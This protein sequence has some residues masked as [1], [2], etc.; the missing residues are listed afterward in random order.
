MNKTGNF[1][2]GILVGA[3]AGSA[4]SLLLAPSEGSNVRDKLSYQISRLKDKILSLV[5]KREDLV[6]EAKSQGE[7]NV[8]KTQLEA[9][10]LQDDIDRIQKRIKK[11][12]VI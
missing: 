2:A 8:S 7:A 11:K 3:V 5:Q 4:V 10:K 1:I 9:R 6:N 12:L